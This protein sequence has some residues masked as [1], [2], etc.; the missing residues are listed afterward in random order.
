M[1]GAI[2][3]LRRRREIEAE[4]EEELSFHVELLRRDHLQ[5]GFSL[6]AAAAAA[7]KQFG[8]REKIKSECVAI[9]RRNHPLLR[10]LRAFLVLMFVGGVMV[11]FSGPQATFRH[12]SNLMMAVP[13]LGHLL[14][15]AHRLTPAKFLPRN[16]PFHLSIFTEETRLSITAYDQKQRTPVERF[17][18]DD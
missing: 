16:E 15:Y 12:L 4:V 9:S 3:L 18:A 5:Q 2:R 1:K 13:V 10:G 8:D 11:R 6:K 14:I 17:L 7:R